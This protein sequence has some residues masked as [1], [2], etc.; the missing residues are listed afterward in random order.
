MKEHLQ[1]FTFCSQEIPKLNVDPSSHA[2]ICWW[3]KNGKFPFCLNM[4]AS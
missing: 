1:H 3:K 2:T 4:R